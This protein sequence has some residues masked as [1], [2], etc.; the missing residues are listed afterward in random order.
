[1]VATDS[2][3]TGINRRSCTRVLLI[4]PTEVSQTNSAANKA[5]SGLRRADMLKS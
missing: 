3:P 1:M 5:V 2:P 4:E